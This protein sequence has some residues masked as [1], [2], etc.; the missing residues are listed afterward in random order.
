MITHE[1][2]DK[3]IDY[4]TDFISDIPMSLNGYNTPNSNQWVCD[5]IDTV[6]QYITQQQAKEQRA[7]KEHEL[8]GLY[9]ERDYLLSNKPKT[10]YQIDIWKQRLKNNQYTMECLEKQLEEKMK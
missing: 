3:A 5:Q 4:I 8:L 6:N 2:V 10:K 1:E 7:K 9:K